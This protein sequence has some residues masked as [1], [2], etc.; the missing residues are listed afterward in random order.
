MNRPGGW[1]RAASNGVDGIRTAWGNDGGG[2]S[3]L[4]HIRHT[5]NARYYPDPV[6]GLVARLIPVLPNQRSLRQTNATCATEQQY[7]ACFETSAY[8]RPNRLAQYV[9]RPV[10]R[11]CCVL[12]TH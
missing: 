9:V 10:P 2:N 3:I 6:F 11:E 4:E 8:V 5:M 12:R 7:A 1:R